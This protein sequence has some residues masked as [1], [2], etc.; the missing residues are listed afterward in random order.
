M[1]SANMTGMGSG[2]GS[3]MTSSMNMS[4]ADAMNTTMSSANMTGSGSGSGMGGM[5]MSGSSSM[6]GVGVSGMNIVAY[7]TTEVVELVIDN[8][9]SMEHPLHFHGRFVVSGCEASLY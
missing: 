6:S 1:S 3:G 2:S 5:D 7:N 8:Y 4:M 9:H